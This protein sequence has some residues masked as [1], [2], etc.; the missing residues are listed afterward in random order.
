MDIFAK[1]KQ[2][3]AMRA[4]IKQFIQFSYG[5]SAW[6]EL[7]LIEAQV[8]KDRQATMYRKA[9]IR[10][11]IAEWVLGIVVVVSSLGLFGLVIYFI[12]KKQ[13]RW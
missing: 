6:E 7:L 8:R 3:E 10:Q 13:G 9:E 11:A 4:E 1:K 12:G 5:Q 2:A